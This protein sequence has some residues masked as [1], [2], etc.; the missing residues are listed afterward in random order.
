[1]RP[2]STTDSVPASEA[3]D[4]SSILAKGTILL[5]AALYDSN[6]RGCLSGSATKE[7]H[8]IGGKGFG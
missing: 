5:P 8:D 4:A 3:D 1:M 2:C 7:S 6:V